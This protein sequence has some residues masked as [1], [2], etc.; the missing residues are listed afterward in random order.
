MFNPTRPRQQLQLR[1]RLPFEGVQYDRRG[2]LAV[3]VSRHAKA[4]GVFFERLAEPQL[5]LAW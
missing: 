4:G 5:V 2:C 3:N 1:A